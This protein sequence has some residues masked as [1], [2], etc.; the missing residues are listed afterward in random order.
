METID[1]LEALVTSHACTMVVGP[2]GCG[3]T[4]IWNL[5]LTALQQAYLMSDEAVTLTPEDVLSAYHVST[6]PPASSSWLS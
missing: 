1:L 4:S 6:D 2:P 5:L 3:K